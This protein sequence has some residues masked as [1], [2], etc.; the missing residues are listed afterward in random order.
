MLNAETN[1]LLTLN[2]SAP[3]KKN[4]LVIQ[5]SD[6]EMMFNRYQYSAVTRQVIQQENLLP[7]GLLSRLHAS[8]PQH[9]GL[10]ETKPFIFNERDNYTGLKGFHRVIENLKQNG[11]ELDHMNDRELFVEVYSFLATR[12]TLNSINWD[13][14]KNDSVF[15]LCF[16]QPDMIENDTVQKYSEAQSAE[17]RAEIASVYM[18]QTNPH[19]GNQQLNKAWF[20]NDQDEVEFLDGSQHKYPQC[21]LIFDKT[22][23][24]CFSFCTYCFRH[25]QVRG[26]KDMFIQK[27]IDQLH[28][29]LKKHH[30]V[31]DLLITGGDGG[32]MPVNRLAEYVMPL[33]EDPELLHV[34]NVRLA[35]RSLTF[36]PE[37][38]L[39]PKYDKMLELFDT[40]RDN[41]IQLAWMAHF[42][43]PRELLNPSTIAAIRRL[44][45]HGV[46]IRSQSP[47]MNHIS[48][49]TDQSGKVDVDKSAQNWIDLATLLG[50]M[51]IGFHSMYA[52]RPTGE[53]HYYAAPL[54]DIQRIFNK[55]YRSLASINRPSRHLSMTISAGKLAILGYSYV[56]G[57][58]YFALQFT[59]ARNMEWMDQ[60]FLAKWDE[61]QNKINLLQPFEGDQYFYEHEL[62]EIELNLAQALKQHK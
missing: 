48:L 20:V 12:H 7:I 58:K 18:E 3:T 1:D 9:S 8:F 51:S 31:T 44:Q 16:A 28:R 4:H 19:D 32:Y 29:Y 11:I 14:F 60:V 47:I 57:K 26:D 37:M 54:A 39:S 62:K 53:H 38:I 23:Q 15:Q 61:T 25:A 33:I 36:Q 35:S 49:F 17:E 59:E 43:T 42:S 52:A 2:P 30:E 22:T 55:I 6:V 24:N 34:K 46:N 21:Q 40:I 56:S 5:P 45:D 50:M 10:L 41:G 27:D 13:D